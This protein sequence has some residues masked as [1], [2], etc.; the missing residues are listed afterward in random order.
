MCPRRLL[1][2]ELEGKGWE[3]QCLV[4]RL[5][6]GPLHTSL[7]HRELDGQQLKRLRCGSNSNNLVNRKIT[8][9]RKGADALYP[10]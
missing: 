5:G 6:H 9:G 1:M 10:P 3:Q 8:T 7:R 4:P 2:W